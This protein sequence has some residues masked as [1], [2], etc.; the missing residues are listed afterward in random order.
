MKPSKGLVFFLLFSMLLISLGYY[1]YQICFTPNVLVGKEERVFIIPRDADF[2]F[3]QKKF[4]EGNIV[5]DLMSFSFL[6]RLME[7]RDHVKP[8]RYILE[9]NMTNLQV[10]RLL[11][12]GIQEPVKVTFNNVRLIRDLSEKIT[13]N[14]NMKPEEFEAALIEFTMANRS[15]FN[16]DNILCMFIPNTYE[17]YYNVAPE[18]LVD[19]MSKEFQNFWTEERK[20]K[21]KEIGLTPIE[22]SIL[23]S[24]VQAESI[25]ADE[26][27]IIAGLYLNRLKKGIALQA[28][29]T[30][31]YAV[32]DF[33]LKRVLNEHKEI[34][35]PYNTYKYAG[36]PPG[37]INLPE[38]RTL[39]A[40]L[41][42]KKSDY[43]Y[44]CAKE[45]FSGRHN[46][47]S[48]Y[49]QHMNNAIKYQ[50][51]LTIEMK[52]AAQMKK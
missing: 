46:F 29:P 24:I 20:A 23:A 7:Y 15:G 13:K 45:D 32:G 14:L 30:L 21:A 42:F 1:A 11:R 12:A 6:A 51:A 5:Q 10:I 26:A 17:V 9:P 3:V 39:D 8:G 35:S 2:K 48:S 44:M 27:P 28:D 37:P 40:V 49:Q 41:N 19:R 50:R 31:V 34:D 4:H 36:L 47:T 25:R 52:K 16:K 43:I 33:S 22:I 38:I 18:D